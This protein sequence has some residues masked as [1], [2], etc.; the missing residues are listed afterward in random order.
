MFALLP[1]C[2]SL[3]GQSV[4]RMCYKRSPH[5]GIRLIVIGS[6]SAVNVVES[7]MN[8]NPKARVAVIGRDDPVGIE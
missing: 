3:P 1:T 8:R 6:G 5:E 7:S 4:I 2:S